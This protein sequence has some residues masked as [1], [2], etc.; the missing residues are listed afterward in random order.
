MCMEGDCVNAGYYLSL[1]RRECYV[2]AYQVKAWCVGCLVYAYVGV[3]EDVYY[4]VW[5]DVV[6]IL[7]INGGCIIV[8]V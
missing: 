8:Y 2:H 1:M 4:V 3:C 6:V 7:F 5:V